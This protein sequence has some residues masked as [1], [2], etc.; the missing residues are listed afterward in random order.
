MNK[1]FATV[2]VMAALCLTLVGCGS[3]GPNLRP[4]LE[5]LTEQ[6]EKQTEQL[7]QVQDDLDTERKEAAD[8]QK[9][10]QEEIDEAKG[11]DRSGRAERRSG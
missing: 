1:Q 3:D 5:K 6:V 8:T 4:E 7:E 10:L 2:A 9:E 11:G